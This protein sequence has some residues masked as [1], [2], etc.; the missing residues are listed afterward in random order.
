MKAILLLPIP[1]IGLGA[2]NDDDVW[3]RCI[4]CLFV[5]TGLRVFPIASP[6]SNKQ[7]IKEFTCRYIEKSYK[8]EFVEECE[9]I[10]DEIY[11]SESKEREVRRQPFDPSD[12]TIR[13]CKE[14]LSKNYCRISKYDDY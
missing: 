12:R 2:I 14:G 1:L 9:E 6:R 5:V 8:D 4:T 3:N 10:V 7:Q 11:G 13:F